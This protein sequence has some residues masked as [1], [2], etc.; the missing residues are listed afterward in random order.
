MPMCG[1]CKVQHSTTDEVREHYAAKYAGT[2]IKVLDVKEVDTPICDIHIETDEEAAAAAAL[3]AMGSRSNGGRV[4]PEWPPSAKQVDY[5]LGLQDERDLPDNWRVYGADEL[6]NMEKDKVSAQIT[7]LKLLPKN[8]NRAT[9]RKQYNLPAGRYAILHSERGDW[10]FFEVSKPTQGRWDG[11][12]FIKRLIGAPGDYK[13]LDMSPAER[14]GWLDAIERD[15]K[16][17]MID[18]GLQSGVCGRCSSPLS[19]PT[20]LARGM[21]PDCAKKGW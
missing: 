10:W 3:D 12:T 21:G 13:K 20:S 14:A 11:Y 8:A 1:V 18:Y 6:F 2:G 19:D 7:A 9:S 5:V 17:A 4:G 15:P 16:H